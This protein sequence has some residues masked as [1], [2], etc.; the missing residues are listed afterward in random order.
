MSCSNLPVWLSSDIY[1]TNFL[2]ISG[3]S[4]IFISQIVSVKFCTQMPTEIPACFKFDELTCHVKY[5]S[6]SGEASKSLYVFRESQKGVYKP[7]D[8]LKVQ[9]SKKIN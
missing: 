7:T 2:M 6:P 8:M 3:K 1:I 9:A 4:P 5:C